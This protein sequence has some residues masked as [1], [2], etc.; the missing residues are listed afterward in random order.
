M[1]EGA[2]NWMEVRKVE[3][4]MESRDTFMRQIL[5]ENVLKQLD[6]EMDDV[7]PTPSGRSNWTPVRGRW[8][9]G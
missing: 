6:M 3:A 9:S 1:W 4:T 5:K 7:E 8:G 2:V